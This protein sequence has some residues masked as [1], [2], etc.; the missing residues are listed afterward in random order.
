[1]VLHVGE[2]SGTGIGPVGTVC[3]VSE[4]SHLPSEEQ[5]QAT[6]RR[7]RRA[8]PEGPAWDAP[9]WAGVDSRSG[10]VAEQAPGSSS[11]TASPR[12][13]RSG[14]VL[15]RKL[16]VGE[17]EDLAEREADQVAAAVEPTTAADATTGTA[18]GSAA[19]L[20]TAVP[21]EVAGTE[22]PVVGTDEEDTVRMSPMPGHGQAAPADGWEDQV[23]AGLHG[24]RPLPEE[25]RAEVEDRTGVDLGGVRL[26]DDAAADRAARA[27]GARAF[28]L[29]DDVAFRS[30]E[31]RPHTAAGRR[32]IAH[33][34][35]HV[36]Q[37]RGGTR[38]A[39]SAPAARAPAGGVVRR[40][41]QPEDV[42][43]EMVGRVFE[44][45]IDVVVT[46]VTLK[47]GTKLIVGT[48]DNAADL[49]TVTA[50]GVSGR[51]NVAK[52]WVLPSR[53]AA[54]GVDPYSAGVAGQA[55]SFEKGEKEL[56][57][58]IAKE[59]TFKTAKAKALF[60]AEKA[61][62]EGEQ[63]VRLKSL[64]RKLIQETMWNRF[65][66][67]I[68]SEVDAANTA[69][70]LTGKA[71][72]DPNLVKAM[73]F[74]ES[75]LG[76]SGTHMELTPSHP[77]KTRFNLGQVIDSSGMALL[78]LL[79]RERPTI[80]TTRKIGTL[81]ADL[82]AAQSELKKL[83]AKKSRTAAEETRLTELKEKSKQSWEEFIWT[84]PGFA[85]AVDDLFKETSPAR[86]FDYTFWIHMAV[87]W[88]FQKR[89]TGMSWAEAAR[90]Y[91]G[92]GPGA[93]AYRDAVVAR[94]AGAAK[95]AKAG[96]PFTP[97]RR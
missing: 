39:A 7:S 40:A 2:Q 45:R 63:A 11:P 17:E 67:I 22:A 55:G 75:E 70:G 46:G 52:K 4:S 84:Y 96:K 53:T 31:Y 90:A 57:D 16:E 27:V 80:V 20:P 68:K 36:A 3:D 44:L 48:W 77:S 95:A 33:E 74:Q 82:G 37:Q 65:D 18:T 1:V 54:S 14:K 81:R 72:L 49:V 32:L 21:A 23:Q 88:L 56:A 30:G 83:K 85:D 15:R 91:N 38:S 97:T 66:T 51:F 59:P 25:D 89:R 61:R 69:A 92:S 42:A 50:V 34:L 86:N 5:E 73:L 62:L 71:A 10:A 29:G 47:A 19:D 58:W 93:E 79:E 78:T 87:M 64:N 26:H 60:A 9:A 12:R 8:R 24:G 76:T 13:D 43:V 6:R 28:T 94:A 41:I 35:T